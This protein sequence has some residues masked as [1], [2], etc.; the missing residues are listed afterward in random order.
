MPFNPKLTRGQE[1]SWKRK[2][3]KE[4]STGVNSLLGWMKQEL[5]VGGYYLKLSRCQ[6]RNG[7]INKTM[8]GRGRGRGV[9]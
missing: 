5:K 3:G 9:K 2:Q 4:K 8:T 1:I 7:N 6:E